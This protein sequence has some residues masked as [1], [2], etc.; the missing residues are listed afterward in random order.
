MCTVAGI[1]LLRYFDSKG[2][3]S[4]RH[5]VVLKRPVPGVW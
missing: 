2:M 5:V 4:V 3:S 1:V